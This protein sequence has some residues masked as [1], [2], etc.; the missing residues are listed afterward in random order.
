MFGKT[1][2]IIPAAVLLLMSPSAVAGFSGYELQPTKTTSDDLECH[3][4][5]IELKAA[6]Q[7]QEFYYFPKVDLACIERILTYQPYLLQHVSVSGYRA[8]A[9]ARSESADREIAIMR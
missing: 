8:M 7:S 3:T 5:A 2:L 9:S 6:Q 1:P 4:F